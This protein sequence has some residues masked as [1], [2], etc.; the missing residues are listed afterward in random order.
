LSGLDVPRHIEDRVRYMGYLRR[1]TPTRS[2]NTTRFKDYVL[3]TVGGGGDGAAVIQQIFA[4]REAVPDLDIPLVVV[5]GPFMPSGQR[6]QFMRWA[7]TLRNVE[8]I[9]F[10]SRFEAL[11]SGAQGVVSMAGYNTFCEILSFDK[12]ALLLPRAE[13]RKEQT[14]RAKRAADLGL[15][16][17]MTESMASDP[18]RLAEA[19]QALPLRAPPS[20]SGNMPNLGG[21]KRITKTLAAHIESTR[22]PGLQYAEAE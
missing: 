1:A 7:K 11:M 3:V 14:V 2:A 19:I 21:Q 22:A 12:P 13:P 17:M 16:D 18:R 5:L 20:K 15:A 6:R 9:E 8:V 4:A 10:E